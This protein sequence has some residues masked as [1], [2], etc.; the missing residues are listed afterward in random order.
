MRT[1]FALVGLVVLSALAASCATSCDE[2]NATAFARM[3]VMGVPEEAAGTLT[4]VFAI[5]E[6]RFSF[7]GPGEVQCLGP[8]TEAI[9]EVEGFLAVTLDLPDVP[10]DD[11][12]LPIGEI[13]T[14]DVEPD[15]APT[16]EP[17]PVP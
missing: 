15:P 16:A 17:E 3:E 10:Q 4:C 1:V 13:P 11:C 7:R 2:S 9:V 12:G 5:G 14:F 8:A 6:E